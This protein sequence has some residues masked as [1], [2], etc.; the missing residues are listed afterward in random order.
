MEVQ[1]NLLDCIDGRMVLWIGIDI[2]TIEIDAIRVDS[3]MPTSHAIR[4]EDGK[5]IEYE[6]IP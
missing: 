1:D 5:Q 3:V 2:T 4:V 6:F